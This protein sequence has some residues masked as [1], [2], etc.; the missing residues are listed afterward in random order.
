MVDLTRGKSMRV[1]LL[2]CSALYL[3]PILNSPLAAAGDQER[4]VQLMNES[5]SSIDIGPLG[6]G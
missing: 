6:G 3:I 2:L 1:F 5:K 4:F